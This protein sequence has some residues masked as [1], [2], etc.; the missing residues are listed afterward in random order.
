MGDVNQLMFHYLYSSKFPIILAGHGVRASNAINE[1]ERL[2]NLLH[3]PVLTTWRGID[4]ISENHHLYFGRP[5]LL[6]NK[7]A[8]LIEDKADLI[9]CIGARMDLMQTSWHPEQ[10]TS[11]AKKIIIDI[12]QNELDKLS[13]GELK[14]CRDIKE[15]LTSFNEYY[16]LCA[17]QDQDNEHLGL[18]EKARELCK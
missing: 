1:F 12:D 4:L 2:I 17:T 16:Y 10:Y 18:I 5:G 11:N 3:I 13:F 9:I 8:K 7:N 15:F 14:I 6:N